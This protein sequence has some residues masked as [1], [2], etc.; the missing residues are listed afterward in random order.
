MIDGWV[1]DPDIDVF[2]GF[3]GNLFVVLIFYIEVGEFGEGVVVGTTVDVN[4]I[5]YMT[6]MMFHSTPTRPTHVTLIETFFRDRSICI[7]YSV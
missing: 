7:Q 6:A 3:P 4:C 5:G 2:P 1:V